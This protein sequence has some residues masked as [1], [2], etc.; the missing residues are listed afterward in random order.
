MRVDEAIQRLVDSGNFTE[1]Q[2]EAFVLRDVEA[3]PRQAA[4]DSMGISVNV[5]DKHLRAA[6]DKV[7]QA[8]RTIE[9]VADVRYEEIPDECSECG[10]TLGGPF[11]TD[12]ERNPLCRD[13]AGIDPAEYPF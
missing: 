9:A 12:E 7:E 5:L 13:C 1:R 6:R 10:S 2:A 8:E 11:A 4:A 3:T